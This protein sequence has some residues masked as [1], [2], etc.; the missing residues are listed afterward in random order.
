MAFHAHTS[1]RWS[2][3]WFIALI[4]LPIIIWAMLTFISTTVFTIGFLATILFYFFAR[5][6]FHQSGNRVRSKEKAILA[7]GIALLLSCALSRSDFVDG[8]ITTSANDML[9]VL[10]MTLLVGTYFCTLLSIFLPEGISEAI[11]NKVDSGQQNSF[12]IGG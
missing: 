12:I 5:K 7:A 10:E 6:R 11:E 3:R 4:F 2:E 9:F 1:V 8:G